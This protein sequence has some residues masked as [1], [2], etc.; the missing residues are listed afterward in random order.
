MI[1]IFWLAEKQADTNRSLLG[2][3]SVIAEQTLQDGLQ[4][5]DTHIDVLHHPA[6]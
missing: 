3:I 6:V 2:L 1:S 4:F 5:A